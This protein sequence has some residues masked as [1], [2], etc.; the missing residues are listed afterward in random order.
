MSISYC[1]KFCLAFILF[2]SYC[3]AENVA[4]FNFG[5]GLKNSDSFQEITKQ[6]EKISPK[7]FETNEVKFFDKAKIGTDDNLKIGAI[8]F[9]KRYIT[10]SSNASN[11]KKQMTE[12]YKLMLQTLE[13]RYG[14]FD[15]SNARNIL[16]DTQTE[17][18]EIF[19]NGL[20]EVSFN[21]N[22]KSNRLSFIN[23]TLQSISTSSLQSEIVMKLAYLDDAH[24]NLLT[25]RSTKKQDV[26]TIDN[27]VNS[28][29]IGF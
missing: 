18:D 5:E 27:E 10:S 2:F 25:D 29:F 21:A 4:G 15:K 11:V 22:P 28:K 7:T 1:K 12:D 24:L 23:F 17:S 16:N 19:L 3:Y 6:S 13:A 9:T 26:E 8:V 20:A 14:E